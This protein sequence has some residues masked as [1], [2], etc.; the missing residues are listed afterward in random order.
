MVRVPSRHLA[1]LGVCLLTAAL[2]VPTGAQAP[3]PA[4]L[5]TVAFMAGC[6]AFTQGERR[7]EEQWMAPSGGVMLGM[8]RSVRPNRPASFE[9]TV[10][11]VV[12]GRL[13]YEAR[14]EGQA[15]TRFALTAS[16]DQRAVFENP[17]HDFPQRITYQRSGDR[18]NAR[19]EG[20]AS[21]GTRG[22]DYPFEKVAC[23]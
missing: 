13:V 11:H 12:E 19:I 10:L 16:G 6:W 8:S 17:A 14:P 2:A 5:D 20:P 21:N 1:P 9:F 22:V 15:P 23:H 7:V 4:P 3:V 18:L